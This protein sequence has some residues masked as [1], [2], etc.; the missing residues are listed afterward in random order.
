VHKNGNVIF[1]Q[2]GG[3][4]K[5]NNILL[6]FGM[7]K[8]LLSIGAFANKGCL[9]VFGLKKC[10][11][12]TIIKPKKMLLEE[13]EIIELN[14]LYKSEFFYHPTRMFLTTTIIS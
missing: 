6:V 7:T 3:I 10:W 13:L 14:G 8:N 4:K 1:S 9:V 12:L 5:I 11:V 2:N